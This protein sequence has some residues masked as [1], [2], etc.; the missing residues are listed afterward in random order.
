MSV[1]V[2]VSSLCCY[3]FLNDEQLPGDISNSPGLSKIVQILAPAPLPSCD[4]HKAP[5]F[6]FFLAASR[7]RPRGG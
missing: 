7:T 2:C 6:F 1:R 4:E 3:L 5:C